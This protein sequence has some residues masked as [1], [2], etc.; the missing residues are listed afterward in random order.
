ME[1]TKSD[2]SETQINTPKSAR[3]NKKAIHL[4][5][6]LSMNIE[7]LETEYKTFVVGICG[8]DCAGKREMIQYMFENINETEWKVRETG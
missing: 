7:L 1:H 2:D 3:E 5:K 6:L 8:G 4:K